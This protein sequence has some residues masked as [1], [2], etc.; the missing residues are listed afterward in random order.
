MTLIRRFFLGLGLVVL[1]GLASCGGDSGMT[2]DEVLKQLT[3]EQKAKVEPVFFDRLLNGS[4]EKII[5]EFTGY[6]PFTLPP[7]G[8]PEARNAEFVVIKKRVFQQF[9]TAD[10]LLE[11]DYEVLPLAVIR[12]YNL[13]T[14]LKLLQ[15]ADVLALYENRSYGT[16][17]GAI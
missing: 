2:K 16:T 17:N 5:I 3:V 14:V 6:T 10:L 4:D 12:V 1:L 8:T 11:Q 13:K 7:T 9:G 15:S